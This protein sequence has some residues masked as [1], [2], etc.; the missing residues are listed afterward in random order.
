MVTLEI[1]GISKAFGDRVLFKDLNLRIESGQCLVV[2]GRNGSGKT[3]LL[4]IIAG[5]VRPTRGRVLVSDDN[6]V[7]DRSRLRKN[8]GMVAPDLVLYDE[9]T[10][11]ENLMLFA[12][13]RGLSGGSEAARQILEKVGLCERAGDL[14]ATFSSGMK[15]RLK[16]AFAVQHSPPV[17]LLDEP[18]SNLD[19]QGADMVR[20]V[21]SEQK[22]R[23]ILVVATNDP[24][25]KSYGEQFLHL[26]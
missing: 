9:L 5:L 16:Y 24:E 15:Q 20:K 21:I 2:T 14:V 4:R 18:T 13:L 23:G 1:Q 6:G 3:T 12:R 25:E 11:L 22:E 26:G 10:A 8:L 7:M 19:E 17:L